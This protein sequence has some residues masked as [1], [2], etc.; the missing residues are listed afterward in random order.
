MSC[1]P[2]SEW[3]TKSSSNGDTDSGKESLRARVE[4]G[5]GMSMEGKSGG[6]DGELA[7]EP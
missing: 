3:E 4:G 2:D 6:V 5:T 1:H 7:S